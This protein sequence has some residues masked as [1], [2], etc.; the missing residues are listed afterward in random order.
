MA[1]GS[2]L[3]TA[4]RHR[5]FRYFIAAFTTSSIG[6]WAYNVALVVWLLDETGSAGWIA[7]ATVCRFVP[8]LVM[9]AYGGV[10]AD[11]FE[12]IRLMVGLDLAL[13]CLMVAIAVEMAV[14]APPALVVLTAA[15]SSTTATVYE[16]AAAAMTPLLV[17]ER[18]LGSANALRN[19]IDNITVVA[20]PGLGGLLLLVSPPW[21][22]LLFNAATFAVSAILIARVRARSTPVD[23][24][25]GGEAGPL[26]QTLVGIRTIAENASTATLVA[27]SI[28]ATFV[29]GVD[30]VMFVVLSEDLLGTGAEGM[31]YL[32]A[33]L[34]V[35]G[36]LAAP[37]VTRLER[38]PRLGTVILVGMAVYCLPT[39]AFLVTDEPGVG[40]AA[41][42][43]RGAGTL[44]VDILAIT[45]LQRSVPPERLGRVFGAFDSLM[46]M[47]ILIGSSLVPFWI[48]WFGLDSLI[49]ATGLGVPALCLLGIPWL[50]RMDQESAERRARLAPQVALLARCDIFESVSEGALE[51]LAGDAKLIDV[52][53]GTVLIE[54]G[55]SADA[56]YV[57]ESGRFGVSARG[58]GGVATTL[59]EM[60]SG[61]GFGEI[62]LIEGIARTA[63]VTA[64]VDSRVLW[65]DG[66]AFVA[67]LTEETPSVALID[68]AAAR[69]GRTHPSARI[70]RA[71]LDDA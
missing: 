35:G 63:T 37:L 7:A 26:R 68:G 9:S 34:G 32:L 50:R 20:G 28:V 3:T 45:A 49:W 17:P 41:Q 30:T 31:G 44:V 29:F 27:F 15:L 54:E 69:L 16:P 2:G 5:D 21:V 43:A 12:R 24:T 70:T 66:G 42:V 59:P 48:N 56:F 71:A 57:I 40:F 18:D 46:L 61:T 6:S 58:E 47:V 52:P 14:G 4:L 39:L 55:E 60:G 22:T 51:Q 1:S 33:G 64:L 25:E 67:A 62:G 8:S 19:T 11:R 10:I 38:L 13:A 53:A 23:V 36:I 65:V